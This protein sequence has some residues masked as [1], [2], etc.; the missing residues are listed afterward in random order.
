MIDKRKTAVLFSV[1]VIIAVISGVALTALAATGQDTTTAIGQ[2][3]TIP[4]PNGMPCGVGRDMGRGQG[5][6]Q[7]SEEFK[8]NV[9]SIAEKDTDVQGL[10]AKG[11]N[12]TEIRPII[13]SVVNGDGTVTTKATGAIVMLT[14]QGT[15][16]ATALVDLSTKSVTRVDINTRT[17]IDKTQ[18]Q[19][20]T[21]TTSIGT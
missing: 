20:T 5:A 2:N 13:T 10:L 15:G 16:R 11:Y 4:G 18:T 3:T 12:I 8:A 6:I 7:V 19:T 14:N 1:V 21:I 9:I 17:V